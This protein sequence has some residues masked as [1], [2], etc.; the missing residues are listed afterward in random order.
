MSSQ[1]NIHS[2]RYTVRTRHPQGTEVFPNWESS[3]TLY[4]SGQNCESLL[5]CWRAGETKV[6]V[7]T[8]PQSVFPKSLLRPSDFCPWGKWS[9]GDPLQCIFPMR[10]S[11][12]LTHTHTHSPADCQGKISLICCCYALH[13]PET[14]NVVRADVFLCRW[15]PFILGHNWWLWTSDSSVHVCVCVATQVLCRADSGLLVPSTPS[16]P[17]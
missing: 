8:C 10:S 9:S 2:L 6:G 1:V 5:I 15:H 17:R 12:L 16:C 13:Y 14:L 4:Y 3:T 7:M 11:R